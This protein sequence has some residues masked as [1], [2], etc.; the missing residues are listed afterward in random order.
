MTEVFKLWVATQTWVARVLSL[1]CGPFCDPKKL[2]INNGKLPNLSYKQTVAK[3][4]FAQSPIECLI[5]QY[6]V[7]TL[8]KIHKRRC[9]KSHKSVDLRCACPTIPPWSKSNITQTSGNS[10]KLDKIT[11]LSPFTSFGKMT[12][13]FCFGS[14]KM[15]MLKFGLPGKKF[16]NPWVNAWDLWMMNGI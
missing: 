14:R 3:P 9:R 15:L 16:E 12:V 5:I 7:K 4:F 6:F 8:L 10:V 1:G 13:F 2:K 11:P